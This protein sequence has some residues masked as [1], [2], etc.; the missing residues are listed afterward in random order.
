V[1]SGDNAWMT[2]DALIERAAAEVASSVLALDRG[3][4]AGLMLY[5]YGETL[6]AMAWGTPDLE[7]PL[8]ISSDT[9]VELGMLDG[10]GEAVAA[11][12]ARVD[13][14]DGWELQERFYLALAQHVHGLIGHPVLVY[15]SG[16]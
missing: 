5:M 2:D 4:W 11:L 3:G 9:M 16:A 14:E 10:D 1:L 7:P 15:E 8:E 6:S 13:G 12:R